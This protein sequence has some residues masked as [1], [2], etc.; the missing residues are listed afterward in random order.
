MN[1]LAYE[2]ICSFQKKTGLYTSAW[3]HFHDI[4][5]DKLQNKGLVDKFNK[6]YTNMQYNEHLKRPNL[7]FYAIDQN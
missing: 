3:V 5:L 4:I 7:P 1:N 2:N 6:Y